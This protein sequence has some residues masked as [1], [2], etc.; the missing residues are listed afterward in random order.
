MKKI[1]KHVRIFYFPFIPLLFSLSF[2]F[3]QFYSWFNEVY[4][5]SIFLPLGA[6]I[7][8]IPIIFYI[9]KFF[10]KDDVKAEIFSSVFI[11]LFFS[12]SAISNLSWNLIFTAGKIN[13]GKEDFQ[14]FVS[15]GVLVILFLKLKQ[16][17]KN[18]TQVRTFFLKMGLI[19]FAI[20]LSLIFWKQFQRM[21][22]PAVKSPLVLPKVSVQA[23]D[24]SKLPD[25]YFIEPEDDAA[26]SVYKNYFNYDESAFTGFLNKTGFYIANGAT[27]NYPKTFES[28]ASMLNME[29]LDYLSKYKNS[30]DFTIVNRL[31]DSN[32][33]MKFLR[34][35][36]YKYYQMGSWWG[37]TQYDPAADDNF[38]IEADG[39]ISIDSFLYNLA[40]STALSTILNKI[41]PV[42]AIGDSDDDDRQRLIYQFNKLPQIV[43][44]PGPKFIFAHIIAPHEPYVFGKNCEVVDK[45]ITLQRTEIENYVNQTG[46]TNKNL[47]SVIKTIIS[48]SK[49][50]PVIIL[51]TDEGVPF[52]NEQLNP[53][54]NWKSASATIVKE[55]F[56]I[57]AAFYLP[58]VTT[59]SFNPNITPV[60]VFRVVLNAYFNTGL[61]LLPDKNYI[62]QDLGNLY[63]FTDVTNIV[64]P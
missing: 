49:N 6:I 27:S 13:F 56:P 52:L 40:D 60:N 12:Y 3:A 2:I 53:A 17:E 7:V 19:I 47:E 62:F 63:E 36:G 5:K 46:C 22:L 34:Q 50:P 24:K 54:D 20:S 61:P 43:D 57:L 41:I 18:L 15:A 14:I 32:N 21:I 28:L 31:I 29:Y 55:K 58:G 64:N 51:L 38:T 8:L 25:I 37:P 11:V 10:L 9:F 59:T 23:V 26:P 39:R 33:V 4:I 30:S 44:I 42:E 16:T 35:Y 48:T 1:K 45:G